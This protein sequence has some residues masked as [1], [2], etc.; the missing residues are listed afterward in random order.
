MLP[1]FWNVF[2]AHLCTQPFGTEVGCAVVCSSLKLLN[3][4]CFTSLPDAGS[5]VEEMEFNWDEYLEDTG[6]TAAPHGS[7]KHVSEGVC[8]CLAFVLFL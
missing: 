3:Y 7:F 4:Q 2:T 5:S 6:A 8:V 1:I